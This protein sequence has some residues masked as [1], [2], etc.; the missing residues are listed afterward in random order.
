MKKL[1]LSC[2]MLLGVLGMYAQEATRPILLN[3]G[4]TQ[5]SVNDQG[6]TV[7][8]VS[9][10]PYGDSTLENLYAATFT[11]GGDL[12][13]MFQYKNMPV[14][15]DGV[16][17]TK[18]VIK[19]AEPVPDGFNIHAYGGQSNFTSLKDLTEYEIELNGNPIDD[20]TIFNWFGCRAS[21]TI[22]EAYFAEPEDPGSG[23]EPGDEPEWPYVQG[24]ELPADFATYTI[25]DNGETRTGNLSLS[26]HEFRTK[27]AQFNGPAVGF[28]DEGGNYYAQVFVRSKDQAG[29]NIDEWDS[30]LFISLPASEA[31][32]AGDKI[33]LTMKVKADKAAT[34]A[35]QSHAAPGSYMH[36]YC[37][38][39]VSATTEWAEFTKE[40][41]A[42][43]G[44]PNAQGG[45]DYPWG[46]VAEG[47]YTIAFNLAKG[48]MNNVC[49]KDITVSVVK[50]EI[51]ENWVDLLA[52][53]DEDETFF[54]I[55]EGVGGPWAVSP[56]DGVYSVLSGDDPWTDWDTQFFVRLPK[57]LAEGTKYKVSFKYSASQDG[58]AD[59]QVHYEPTEYKHYEFIGSPSFTTTE[60]TYEKEGTI[61]SNQAGTYTITFN[62]SKNKKETTFYFSDFKFEVPEGT[63]LEDAPEVPERLF[64]PETASL[65]KAVDGFETLVPNCSMDLSGNED[66][67]AYSVA[68]DAEKAAV[69][70]E[71]ITELKSARAVL[72]DAIAGEHTGIALAERI[73][74]TGNGLKNGDDGNTKG[75]GKTKYVLADG[76]Q[77]IGFYLLAD[78]V[79]IP[80]GKGYLVIEEAAAGREFIGFA[81]DATTIKTVENLKKSG[82]IYNLAGQQVKSAQ[83]GIF[84]IDGKKTILK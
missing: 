5:E 14:T 46:K 79:A 17:Y 7:P 31:L 50:A 53:A 19:F 39:N 11:P 3:V 69:A 58:S 41:E 81:D 6:E 76:N 61:S 64:K 56:E 25:S 20:F 44:T 84:I 34:F 60:K 27:D 1:L 2:M 30:Q 32:N 80:K 21:I 22:T 28:Q 16:T 29:T 59:T 65:N 74:N 75:D 36:W 33:K 38:D 10:V 37:V 55:E 18:I 49:F 42:A 68:Y 13:N 63:E 73:E 12:Q 8:A 67:K 78:G 82:I 4:N 35:T 40:I 66:I 71:P 43:A 52:D 77:G 26:V 51:V 72:I 23:D 70:L 62:L 57:K 47:M 9:I 83:K 45:L 24:I 54:K 15:Y 48:D